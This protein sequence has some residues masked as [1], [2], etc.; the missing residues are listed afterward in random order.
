M[1]SPARSWRKTKTN[2]SS[3]T[4]NKSKTSSNNNN[5][6]NNAQN[7][8]NK[9]EWKPIFGNLSTIKISKKS[10][11]DSKPR[12]RVRTVARKSRASVRLR[13]QDGIHEPGRVGLYNLGNTCF[14]NSVLQSLC[15]TEMFKEINNSDVPS[16]FPLKPRTPSFSSQNV[17]SSDSSSSSGGKKSVSYVKKR[18]GPRSVTCLQDALP[19]GR[20]DF[21]PSSIINKL[22]GG[23][24][25]NSRGRVSRRRGTKK[26]KISE[27]HPFV[28]NNTTNTKNNNNR[29]TTTTHISTP[30]P[31]PGI[32]IQPNINSIEN[33]SI[34][35]EIKI[36]Y[37]AIWKGKH[38]AFSTWSPQ[39][40]FNS[41]TRLMP[42]FGGNTQQD[43]HDFLHYLLDRLKDEKKIKV[44]QFFGGKIASDVICG[45]CGNHR[46]RI[47][48]FLDLSLDYT[49]L[50]VN[51]IKVRRESDGKIG[52]QARYLN[53]RDCLNRF[54]KKEELSPRQPYACGNCDAIKKSGNNVLER[55]LA[56]Y[57]EIAFDGKYP[58]IGE[59][60][61]EKRLTISALPEILCL[62][63]KRWRAVGRFWFKND[64]YVE[65]PLNDLDLKPHMH[66]DM[67]R[68][69]D[70]KEI[71]SKELGSI[72][73]LM[74]VICHHGAGVRSGHYT[75]YCRDFE[76]DEWIHF[77]DQRVTPVL[78]ASHVQTPDAYILL[79]KR[80]YSPLSLGTSDVEFSS[81]EDDDEIDGYNYIGQNGIHQQSP[82][83]SSASPGSNSK[84]SIQKMKSGQHIAFV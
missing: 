59:N 4:K 65:Y 23:D 37:E 47:E 72:Y 61:T 80:K 8:T 66:P 33:I 30:K 64:R 27:P 81:G 11:D 49:M 28:A 35:K 41:I 74:A 18:P 1:R 22:Q 56:Q 38:G 31:S 71:S 68:T 67:T 32:E 7:N 36:I 20:K 52:F 17:R 76:K 75:S 55:R 79:Y 83:S 6:A 84:K 45:R 42:F 62:H 25:N 77:D 63:L 5:R 24:V 43:A 54:T 34:T 39:H 13:E 19:S 3:T 69:N 2:S 16:N 48:M 21:A 15:Y 70:G 50:N 73:D 57:D 40:F 53:L 46:Q 29:I 9:E 51:C 60:P 78:D 44:E 26:Q 10:S 58:F 12:S 14:M 82:K